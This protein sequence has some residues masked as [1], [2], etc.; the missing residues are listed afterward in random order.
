MLNGQVA[1]IT[2]G[3]GD[4][5]RAIALELALQGADISVADVHDDAGTLPAEIEALGQRLHYERCDVGNREQVARWLHATEAALDLP[6]IVVPN[7]A[8]V[9]LG[10][11]LDTDPV[12]WE[13]QL[14][15][16]LT[17]GYHTAQ[18]AARRLV[19]AQRSGRIVF[20]GSWAAHAPDPSILAYCAA[21]AGLRMLMKCLAKELAPHGI[22]VNE[23][24]PGYVD[25]G[26]SAQV[27]RDQ[28][29]RRAACEERVP[30]R[31]LIDP[32]E[33]AHQVVHLVDPRVRHTTGSVL[34]MDGGLSL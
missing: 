6:T 17:G 28:P 26:V 20:V 3:L 34:L 18:L 21:K 29:G 25:A 7:A 19:A 32:R 22:L 2:G 15:V 14:R 12:D 11:A 8:V 9:T 1:A 23:V 30:V 24:A 31:R 10:S 4:I 33:V 16:N 13:R 5:G 27:F